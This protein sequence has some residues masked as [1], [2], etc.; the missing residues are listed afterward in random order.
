MGV[1]AQDGSAM[2]ARPT[3]AC[4]SS[5]R[6]AG[7]PATARPVNGATT[8]MVS[9]RAVASVTTSGNFPNSPLPVFA[10]SI[11]FVPEYILLL[12]RSKSSENRHT[13][14]AMETMD[15]PVIDEVSDVPVPELFNQDE[16]L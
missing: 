11:D 13:R 3:A 12:Q 4:T 2:R 6:P 9:D 1:P 10:P 8:S 15:L 7:M 16:E 5:S 14:C